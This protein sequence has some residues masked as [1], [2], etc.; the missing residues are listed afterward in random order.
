M[1]IDNPVLRNQNVSLLFR[2]HQR[3]EDTMPHIT[4]SVS[5]APDAQ[6]SQRLIQSVGR[7]TRD[8]LGKEP[9]LISIQVVWTPAEQ[10]FIEG[11]S[12]TEWSKNAFH[13]DISITDETN[14]KQ[15]K[16]RFIAETFHALS[17]ILGNVHPFSYI[18]VID[19]RA[20][21]YGYGG[22]TQEYR[23]QHS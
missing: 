5:G 1:I 10:W 9:R 2:H 18:H 17:E 8:I 11:K 21:A 23:I 4:L 12:L 19:A 20:A 15:E 7:L 22:L 3:Q 6:T 14:T 16:A 13:L